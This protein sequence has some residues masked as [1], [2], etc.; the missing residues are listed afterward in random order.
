MKQFFSFF[1]FY[2][3]AFFSLFLSFLFRGTT[4]HVAAS[5]QQRH[6]ATV[7]VALVRKGIYAKVLN[8][9]RY[10]R[11]RASF[12]SLALSVSDKTVPINRAIRR[13][14]LRQRRLVS[15]F[16]TTMSRVAILVGFFSPSFR[17]LWAPTLVEMILRYE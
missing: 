5:V 16:C 12:L 1:F 4:L 17:F 9:L 10:V 2:I 15:G 8:T 3:D 6:S 7:S 11:E 13:Q 14:S